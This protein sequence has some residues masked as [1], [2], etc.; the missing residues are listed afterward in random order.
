MSY[1]THN[2]RGFMHQSDFP[3][4]AEA[5][6]RHGY[7]DATVRK[8]LGGNWRRVYGQAWEAPHTTADRTTTERTPSHP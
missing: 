7:D 3:A 6:L 2:I 5:L 4:V 1:A 8:I